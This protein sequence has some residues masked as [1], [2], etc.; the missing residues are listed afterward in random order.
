MQRRLILA[1]GSPRRREL[2]T[3]AGVL[4]RVRTAPVEERRQPGE[5]PRD[6]VARLAVE[7][8]AAVA[9]ADDEL[10]LAADTT[11][12]VDGHALEK[13]VDAEDA[14]GMLRRISGRRHQVHTGVCLRAAEG[15]WVQVATTEVEFGVIPEPELGAYAESEEPRDKAGAYAIQ[16]RASR[17]VTRIDGCFFNVVGLPV[18]VVCELIRGVAPELLG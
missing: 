17:W 13:P 16:G 18:P 4:F 10:I 3:A 5:A 7:K 9:M 2:L 1:S 6:Y 14:R 12:D 11:V 8:A 15:Q